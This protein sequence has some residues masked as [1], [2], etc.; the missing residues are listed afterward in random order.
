MLKFCPNCGAKI[1]KGNSKFCPNCGCLLNGI[2]NNDERKQPLSVNE[3]FNIAE[4]YKNKADYEQAIQWYKKAANLNCSEAMLTLCAIYYQSGLKIKQDIKQSMYWLKKAASLNNV[5][6]LYL[7]GNLYY[8]GVNGVPKNDLEAYKLIKK[9]LDIEKNINGNVKF[10]H[11]LSDNKRVVQGVILDGKEVY[12]G[13]KAICLFILGKLCYSGENIEPNYQEAEKYLKEALD[14]GYSE[15]ENELKKVKAKKNQEEFSNMSAMSA[16]LNGM[17]SYFTGKYKEAI[18]NLE[19]GANNGDVE[20]MLF[21]GRIYIDKEKDFLDYPKA[22]KWFQKAAELGNSQAM[23]ELGNIYRKGYGV[24]KNLDK[25]IEWYI[26]ADKLNDHMAASILTHQIYNKLGERLNLEE[27]RKWEQRLHE[28]E[29][30]EKESDKEK[31]NN[32]SSKKPKS[33]LKLFVILLIIVL[34]LYFIFSDNDSSK[35]SK[36][37]SNTSSIT[38]S[39]ANNKKKAVVADSDL[40]L[41]G[42]ALG[43]S[44]DQMHN[45]LGRETSIEDNGMYK[46]YNYSDIQVGI[47]DGKVDSLVSNSSVV[48]TK[49]GIHQGSNLQ[50][51][52]NKYGDNY[53]KT[54]YNDLILYEY[55]FAA[56]N[57]KNG[58]LR[59]AINK[60]NNQVNYIS[61]RIP[62]ETT[63]SSSAAN[64]AKQVLNNYYAAITRH[65][66]R[67]A[68]NILSADMQTHMGSLDVYADGYKTTLSDEIFDVQVTSDSGDEIAFSYILTA[69]DKYNNG[70]KEQT[71]ACTALLSKKTGSWHIVDMSA[72]KQSERIVSR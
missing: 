71:F 36:S 70:V 31:E 62:D 23:I 19:K 3:I 66:M 37:I 29:T 12:H 24:S 27:Q 35:K 56:D 41:G 69:R 38:N 67:V 51:V 63:S 47:K 7:L 65:D 52:L 32:S 25:A 61:V 60:S 8:T 22:I 30:K 9:A 28:I 58:I 55:T 14:L 11:N 40:S 34:G 54:D 17:V 39:S 18:P 50:D 1:L 57:G 2:V 20:S 72:K 49:R 10:N 43:Y 4:E 16:S 68:Y 53:S 33:K 42:V 44:I 48:E 5:T 45:I 13:M 21:L 6:A 15:A 46:F 26:K 64:E 59:F